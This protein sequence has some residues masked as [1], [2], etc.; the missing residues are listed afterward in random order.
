MNMN[1]LWN[2]R[3]TERLLGSTTFTAAYVVS[4]L[5]GSLLSF[6]LAP[7]AS[8]GASGAIMGIF[9]AFWMTLYDNKRVLGDASKS[10]RDSLLSSVG[11][12][13]AV[14]LFI[15]IVDNWCACDPPLR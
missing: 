14:G 12:T 15:P 10:V 6:A 8:V 7:Q 3:M 4:G 11:I 1:A 13:L 2:A 9:G 5:A